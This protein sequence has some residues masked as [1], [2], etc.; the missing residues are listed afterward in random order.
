MSFQR[1]LF[2]TL[3]LFSSLTA[4]LCAGEMI[5]Q[6]QP[7]G[8]QG[9][10][11]ATLM[12]QTEARQTLNYGHAKTLEVAGVAHGGMKRL[13]LIVFS[14][15]TGLKGLPAG[16]RIK[17]ATLKLYKVGEPKDSGQYAKVIPNHLVIRAARLLT[18]WVAGT[19]DGETEEG[20]V[21]FAYRAYEEEIPKFWGDTNRIENGPVKGI[22]FQETGAVACRLTPG[23]ESGWMEWDITPFVQE[24]IANPSANHGVLLSAKSFYVGSYFA[25]CEADEPEF[26]PKLEI[27]Y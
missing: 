22:D 2:Y 13:G 11:D 8:Y 25:S 17:R 10:S 27:S 5:F 1:P 24:W 20:S 4:S 16:V 6:N 3:A 18:P 7:D 19:R 9:A 15:L 12:G 21:T 14:D 23:E 26:R